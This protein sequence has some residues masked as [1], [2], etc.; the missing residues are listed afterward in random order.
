MAKKKYAYELTASAARK[1][2][3]ESAVA[4]LYG[5]IRDA[6]MEGRSCV[7]CGDVEEFDFVASGLR[8]NGY[9][10]GTPTSS[11]KFVISWR[12]AEGSR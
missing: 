10:V 12:N 4:R 7:L 8:D 2:R 6:C 1:L 11:G 5:A 9:T 3:T